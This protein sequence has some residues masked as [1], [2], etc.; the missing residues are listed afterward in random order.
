MIVYDNGT[1][2]VF[3]DKIV[4]VKYDGVL[5]HFETIEGTIWYE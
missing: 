4:S 5:E 3:D 2:Y 1:K